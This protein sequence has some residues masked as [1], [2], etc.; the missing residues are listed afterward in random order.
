VSRT[1]YQFTMG[2]PNLDDLNTWVP[3]LID[4]LNQ[5]KEL[6]DVASDL[7]SQGLQAYLE[8]DRD[9]AGRLGITPAA[10]D[11]I[12]Y[13]ACGQPLIW[14]I[15]REPNQYR[16][17]LEVQPELQKGPT[18]LEKIYIP[19]LS[20]ANAVAQ[21]VTQSASGSAG[22]AGAG[23]SAFGGTPQGATPG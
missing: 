18:S 17:V 6:A 16:V 14:T 15:Y 3:K 5:R 13:D 21:G 20:N 7:Q 1:Q 19:G 22:N 12:R 2:S 10:I 9:T 11:Q 8:I 4:K 23:S